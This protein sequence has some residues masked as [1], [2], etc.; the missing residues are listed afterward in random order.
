MKNKLLLPLALLLSFTV[1]IAEAQLL[2]PLSPDAVG[3]VDV[4]IEGG[5]SA[6]GG[7]L[8]GGAT[9][10][11]IDIDHS[12]IDPY[13]LYNWCFEIALEYEVVGPFNEF[14]GFYNRAIELGETSPKKILEF[15]G[16]V[17]AA[18]PGSLADAIASFNDVPELIDLFW[19][20]PLGIAAEDVTYELFTS[21]DGLEIAVAS[22]S[23]NPEIQGDLFF[24]GEA[25]L[26]AKPGMAIPEPSTY[27]LIGAGF[28]V[29]VVL[30]RRKSL[31]RK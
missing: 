31:S 12:N 21:P 3:Y 9:V 2:G 17:A 10:S 28:L 22:D 8:A 11:I 27:G 16:G 19:P 20:S 15:I 25:R 13:G 14:P 24:I 1:S 18:S 23:V 26:T 4:V 6:I 30:L 5:G 29:L 7:E